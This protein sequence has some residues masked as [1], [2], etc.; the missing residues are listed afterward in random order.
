MFQARPRSAELQLVVQG[1]LVTETTTENGVL[2]VHGN[3]RVIK[4]E[5]GP[6][7]MTP[8]YQGSIHTQFNP[9]CSNVTFVSTFASEDF[10]TGQIPFELFSVTDHLGPTIAGENI[11]AVRKALPSSVA[12]GVERCLQQCGIDKRPA[13]TN[14]PAS[15]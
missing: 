10:G 12:L 4:N 11:E 2:D 7:Q 8:F 13:Q 15:R 6:Y 9:D 3:P 1:R 14:Q 5:I